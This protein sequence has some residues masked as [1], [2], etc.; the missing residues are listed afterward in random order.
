M[1]IGRGLYRWPTLKSEEF[2]NFF[3]LENCRYSFW[4]RGD[5]PI[6][7]VPYIDCAHGAADSEL[8]AKARLYHLFVQFTFLAPAIF[9]VPASKELLWGPHFTCIEDV[10]RV[11]VT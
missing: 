8:S 10:R 7:T 5:A 3:G 4:L 9:V 1:N 11:T 2:T 6:L